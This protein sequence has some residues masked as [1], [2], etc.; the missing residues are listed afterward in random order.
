MQQV[1]G[2]N[3]HFAPIG[4]LDMY[5]SG[6]AIESLHCKN[7]ISECVVKVQ[8]RG[9]GR[10]GA[11]SNK[12]PRSCLVDKKE[13]IMVYNANDGLLVLKLHGQYSSVTR[14]IEIVY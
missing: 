13:E 4:L 3:V 12:K 1:F 8:I 2:H 9:C 10:F 5:N 14:E 6:G 11:Y 7:E